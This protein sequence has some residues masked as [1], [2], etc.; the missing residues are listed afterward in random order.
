MYNQDYTE[1]LAALHEPV[2]DIDEGMYW[3]LDIEAYCQEG[4]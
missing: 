4:V 2:L 1:D 3:E